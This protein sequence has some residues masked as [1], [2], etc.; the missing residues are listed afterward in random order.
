LAGSSVRRRRLGAIS[1][2]A[3]A[4][5]A[6]LVDPSRADHSP[7]AK[8]LA[9]SKSQVRDRSVAIGRLDAALAQADGRLDDL[10][11]DAELAVERF[12]GARARLEQADRDYR[13]A[14]TRTG[15]ARDR[16]G[17][18]RHQLAIFASRAYRSDNS[19]PSLAAVLGG[20]GGPSGFLER[21]SFMQVLANRQ[22]FAVGQERAA[23]SIADLFEKQSRRA[24]GDQRAATRAAAGAR[25]AATAA[26]ARQRASV[27]RIQQQK[28]GLVAALS[29]AK[30]HTAALQRARDAEAAPKDAVPKGAVRQIARS[31]PH[32]SGLG[33]VAA[34]AALKWLGTPY[35]WGGGNPAGPSL[36]IAQGAHTVGFDCSGLVTYAWARAG[37]PLTHYATSQYNS[38]PHP[39]RNQLRPGDLVFFAHNPSNPSTIHHVGIYI[40]NGQMVE[41]PF[42]GAHVRV[43]SAF[44]PD[45]AGATR[46]A[47]LR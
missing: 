43:S 28:A 42:T 7:G 33:A 31:L 18:A 9:R 11:D 13:D 30:A 15:K 22:N 3:L 27:K 47:G 29:R 40:G 5:T 10:N 20:R 19:Y 36:G 1:F 35:S 39:V 45:Y 6:L 16:L 17:E 12:N 25:Q 37:V 44:R 21:A 46:P 2:A 34:R 26:V 23:H 4:V 14:L 32:A 38:G 24:L 41:A 8:E